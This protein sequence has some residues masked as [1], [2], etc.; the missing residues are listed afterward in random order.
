MWAKQLADL[1]FA[2]RHY[3]EAEKIA[4]GMIAKLRG[5]IAGVLDSETKH[6]VGPKRRYRRTFMANRK[7][8]VI[9]GEVIARKCDIS[10]LR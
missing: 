6:R 9:P 1:H 2:F 10:R 4:D 7:S 5:K 3:D 8:D